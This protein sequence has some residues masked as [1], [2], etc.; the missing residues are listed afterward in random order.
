[1]SP[2]WKLKGGRPFEGVMKD[3]ST[4]ITFGEASACWAQVWRQKMENS[5]LVSADAAGP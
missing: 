2:R 1:M 5:H 3:K 4:G